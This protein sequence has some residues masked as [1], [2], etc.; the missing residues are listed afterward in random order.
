M[1]QTL[2][3]G[4]LAQEIERTRRE[5]LETANRCANSPVRLL[6][7]EVISSAISSAALHACPSC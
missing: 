6:A 2:M 1:M 3:E 4:G 5:R 7:F